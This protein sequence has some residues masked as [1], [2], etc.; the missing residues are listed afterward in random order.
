M[1]P[2]YRP[3]GRR[4]CQFQSPPQAVMAARDRLFPVARV[5]ESRFVLAGGGNK[6][7][8]GLPGPGGSIPQTLRRQIADGGWDPGRPA[9]E[10]HASHLGRRCLSD[11]RWPVRLMRAGKKEVGPSHRPSRRSDA[12]RSE[13]RRQNVCF[14]RS[15]LRSIAVSR[16]K[17]ESALSS[18]SSST[19]F[20]P[21][22]ETFFSGDFYE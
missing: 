10:R 22:C 1:L 2:S 17:D 15:S 12:Q 21:P 20:E 14:C 19:V 18:K 13:D 6:W 5:R 9:C 7:Y 11:V 4:Q 16:Q 8:K 3:T